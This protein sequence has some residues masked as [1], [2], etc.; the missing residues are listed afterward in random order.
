MVVVIVVVSLLILICLALIGAVALTRRRHSALSEAPDNVP[1][2]PHP[3]PERELAQEIG[4]ELLARRVELDARR[5]TLGGNSGIDAE[6][7]RLQQQLRAGEISEE[8]FEREKIRLLS[9]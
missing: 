4:T 2:S 3:S 8:Q 1:P 9:G 7:D 6:F 5:G